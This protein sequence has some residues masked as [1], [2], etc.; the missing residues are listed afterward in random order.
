M[1]S[2]LHIALHKGD[3]NRPM[4]KYW[5]VHLAVKLIIELIKPNALHTLEFGQSNSIFIQY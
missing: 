2:H 5:Y 1:W 3:I 4:T